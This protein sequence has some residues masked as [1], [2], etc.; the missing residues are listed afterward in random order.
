VED[1]KPNSHKFKESQ[2]ANQSEPKVKK[3]VSGGVKTKKKSEVSNLRG[4]FI[5]EDIRNV[6]SYIL[7]DVIIPAI[8]SALSDTVSNGINMLLY[9]EAGRKRGSSSSKISYSQYYSDRNSAVTSSSRS[10]GRTGWDYDEI[11]FDTRGDAERVLTELDE[12][13]DRYGVI[14][15]GDLYNAAGVTT[16]NFTVNKYG[17]TNIRS[18][19]VI[20]VRDGYVIKMPKA[21]PI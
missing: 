8:K 6:G 17:W 11:T 2:Q 3:V 5:S 9:G 7:T 16:D 20:R 4:A 1:Y 19:E 12:A 21:T 14:S 15:V 18:A 13:V 10:L